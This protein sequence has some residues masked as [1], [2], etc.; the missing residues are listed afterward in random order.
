MATTKR[1]PRFL[2]LMRED[3]R[4]DLEKASEENGRTLTAEINARLR[5]SLG[6]KGPT[7]QGILARE[8][9]GDTPPTT[10]L[11]TQHQEAANYSNPT[12][13]DIDRAIL[14]VVRAMPPEKQ[15]ALLSLFK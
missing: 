12:L 9:F 4:A 1:P 11:N 14:Q 8:A 7:L 3:L 15:L 13:S 10:P 6:G 2:L 5:V